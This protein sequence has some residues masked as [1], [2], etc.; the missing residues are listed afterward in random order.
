MDFQ[1]ITDGLYRMHLIIAM[2]LLGILLLNNILLYKQ[3]VR[4][5]MSLMIISSVVMCAF[6][7][8]WELCDGHRDLSALTYA[9]GIGYTMSFVSYK[10]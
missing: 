8:V 3:K 1:A 4:D 5:T 7:M 2:I 6:E 10:L 9:G